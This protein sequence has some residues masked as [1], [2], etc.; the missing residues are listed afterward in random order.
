[1]GGAPFGVALVVIAQTRK[2]IASENFPTGPKRNNTETKGAN[3][4]RLI[5]Q[6]GWFFGRR[7]FQV[8]SRIAHEEAKKEDT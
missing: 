4:A 5:G 8:S 1:M 7:V 2:R 6:T 3:P